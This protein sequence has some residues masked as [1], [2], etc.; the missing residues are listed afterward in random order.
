MWINPSGNIPASQLLVISGTSMASPHMAGI[1]ALLRQLKPDWSVE[2]LKALVMNYAIHDLTLFPAATPPR[3]GPSRIGAG[4]VDPSKAAVG[5]VIAMNAE[6][7][8]GVSVTFTPEVVGVVTQTKKI[9]LV[10]KGLTSP[11]HHL[12]FANVVNSPV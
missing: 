2:E 4:R 6:D 3:F 9:P 10:H 12:A 11:T 1:M 8:G 5:D 7:Q